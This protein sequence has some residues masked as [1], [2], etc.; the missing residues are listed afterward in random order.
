MDKTIFQLNIQT[1]VNFQPDGPEIDG[2]KHAS[3]RI[4][5][6]STASTE[7]VGLPKSNKPQIVF[8]FFSRDS[9]RKSVILRGGIKWSVTPVYTVI[10]S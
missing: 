3:F 2:R 5:I 6:A 10:S 8:T 7:M 9:Q 4:L 1:I